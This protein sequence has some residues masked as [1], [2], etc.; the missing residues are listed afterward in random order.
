VSHLDPATLIDYWTRDVSPEQLDSVEI[1]LFAC[2]ACTAEAE[3]YAKIAGALRGWLSPAIS[4][5]QLAELKAQGLVVEENT[6][7][8]GTRTTVTF[9]AQLDLM[10]HHLAGLDL[11]SA[12]RVE[13]MV[14][15][16]S[17]GLVHHDPF[18]PFD[19][20]RGEI[21]IACQKHF[22]LFPHD[23]VFDVD[24]HRSSGPP[25]RS[26]YELPHVFA[27]VSGALP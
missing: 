10:I 9:G 17:A 14:R 15:S 27:G 1:H 8:P 23:I 21:L 2:D 5:A 4:A 26:T 19:A 12:D 24:V 25:V 7:A 18:A 22:A 20:A 3:R 11:A 6:F 16:E 13:L